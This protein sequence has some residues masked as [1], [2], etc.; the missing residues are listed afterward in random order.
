MRGYGVSIFA[1]R[2]QVYGPEQVS[3][4][5]F[6]VTVDGCYRNVV[7]ISLDLKPHR[8][9]YVKIDS[10]HPVDVVVAREDHSSAAHKEGVTH[11]L[12]G[13]FDT[14][15]AMSMGVFLGVDKGDKALVT[16]EAW[17]DRERSTWICPI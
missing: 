5:D 11:V 13:P 1:K 2:E 17:T 12:L 15:R 3:V 16:L 8:K 4:G 6:D 14:G 9:L 7:P 10:A